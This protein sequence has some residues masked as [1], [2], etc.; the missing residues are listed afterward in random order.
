LSELG[1]YIKSRTLDAAN[2]SIK[3]VAARAGIAFETA[4]R[5]IQGRGNVSDNTL[6]A[7]ADAF[8]DL[9]LGRMRAL[10]G[11]QAIS[12]APRTAPREFD[13]LTDDEW[14]VVVAVGR[15]ILRSSGRLDQPTES[16]SSADMSTVTHVRK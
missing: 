4:R 8:P 12:P 7:L 1:E 3:Q 14:R 11:R 16:G 5:V 2:L 13:Q 15:Q 6:E 10:A 9:N